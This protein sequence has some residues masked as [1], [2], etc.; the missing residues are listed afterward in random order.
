MPVPLAAAWLSVRFVDRRPGVAAL[1][2]PLTMLGPWVFF[3]ES[4]YIA[5]GVCALVWLGTLLWAGRR[6]LGIAGSA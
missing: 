2:V 3:F 6:P 5:A 1:L 4:F